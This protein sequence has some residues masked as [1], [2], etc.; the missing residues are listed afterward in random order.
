MSR[1]IR[2]RDGDGNLIRVNPDSVV[3]V[4]TAKDKGTTILGNAGIVFLNGLTLAVM[5]TVDGVSD[6][7]EGKE[8]YSR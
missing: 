5:G 4:T 8:N 6:Q 3:L 1:F 7:L 2:L